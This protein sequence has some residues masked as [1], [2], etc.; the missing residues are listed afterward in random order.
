MKRCSRLVVFVT[1]LLLASLTLSRGAERQ[2]LHGHVPR[3]ASQLSPVDHLPGS[4]R[5]SLAL[6][7]PLRNQGELT[8]LLLEL[9]DFKSTNYHRFLT[10]EQFTARFGPT[11]EDYQSV[12]S[13]VESNGLTITGKHSNRILLDVDGSV[14]DI[15]KIFHINLLVYSHP[16]EPR[17]FYAPDVEPATDPGIPLLR[18][19]GLDNYTVPHLAGLS[20]L[21]KVS[22]PM[23][24]GGTGPGG[25]YIGN[26]FR[27]AYLPGVSLTGSGQS[28]G[29]LEFDG[30]YT[31]DIRAYETQAGLTNVSLTNVLLDGFVGTPGANNFE[32][33]LDIELAISMAPGLSQVV[34]Y[35]A[36]P[37]GIGDDILSRMAADN[38]AKQLSSSWLWGSGDDPVA[39]Q[40]FQQF[41]A[42]GQSFF[43]AAGDNEAYSGAIPFPADNPFV[44]VVG[45]TTL[46]TS[47]NGSWSSETVWNMNN[48]FGSGGGSSPIYPIP[49]W[50][51]PINMTLNAGS[52]TRRNIPDVAMV[53]SGIAAIW[54][55]GETGTFVGTSC[56]TPLWAAFTALVNQQAANYGQPPVG[57]LNPALY[58]LGQ[59]QN[60][61]SCFHDITVGN[62]TNGVSPNRFNAVAGYD[63][64]TGWGSPAGQALID[65][66]EPPSALVVTPQVGFTASGLPGGPFTG[67]TQT[68]YVSNCGPSS[69]TWSLSNSVTWLTAS[70]T[71]GASPAGAPATPVSVTLNPAANSLASGNYDATIWLTDQ[72]TGLKRSR[73]FSLQ[74]SQSLIRNGGFETGSFTNWTLAGSVF[75]NSVSSSRVVPHSGNYAATFGQA[76]SLAYLSQTLSTIPGQ[77][78]LLSFWLANPRSGTPNQFVAN[79]N[80]NA[81]STNTILLRTNMAAFAWTNIQLVVIATDTNSVLQFALRDDP[82]YLGL[83]DINLTPIP[84]TVLGTTSRT[85]RTITFSWVPFLGLKYQVQYKTDLT[86]A[87]WNNLATS[88]VSTNGMLSASDAIGPDPQRFY[89]VLGAP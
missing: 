43:N 8:N 88:V 52:S 19:L 60:S 66:L 51:Q 34:V 45:G 68:L 58:T 62:N 57:F 64:C 55:N 42:Q 9:Y 20:P 59:G 12:M 15:E 89:R 76:G 21:G 80:T 17:N 14:A 77:A 83:D 71:G 5:L 22:S 18:V 84:P 49:S 24:N 61:S 72:N 82:Q 46:F 73:Q 67:A 63:L 65:A 11:Q 75:A 29:L 85:D 35:E 69:L 26:D 48:G 1:L 13:F 6:G 37:Q 41:A 79:W 36:G 23:P 53:A 10:P 50:Q 7:M 27:A 56:A 2:V 70:P 28:V 4:K 3:A 16:D 38:I 32:V 33:A 78:Y 47:L 81:T 31:N 54:N 44:T 25:S 30:Y 74:I 86:Q 40:I 39:D 87:A